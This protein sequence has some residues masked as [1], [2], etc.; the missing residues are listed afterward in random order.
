MKTNV[1]PITDAISVIKN[2][3]GVS[4]NFVDSNIKSYGVIAQE[5][6]QV[7]PELV[8]N[9]GASK[10]VNMTAIIGFLIEAVKELDAKINGLLGL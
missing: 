4:Y 7:L 6:E 1:Q 9:E 8:N 3:Q 10:S 2:L 5:I